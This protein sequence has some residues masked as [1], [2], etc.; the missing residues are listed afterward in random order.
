MRRQSEKSRLIAKHQGFYLRLL[1]KIREMDHETAE[2]IFSGLVATGKY[3]N[4]NNHQFYWV[5]AMVKVFGFDL[6]KI[7]SQ[8][9]AERLIKS[10]VK[11][12]KTNN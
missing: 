4:P 10:V 7:E 5:R 12:S 1:R 8:R 6:G 11:D 9:A 3:R 2:A